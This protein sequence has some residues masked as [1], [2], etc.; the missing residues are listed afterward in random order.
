VSTISPAG[1]RFPGPDSGLQVNFCKNVS[2]A[3]FG[4]PETLH[5]KRRLPEATPQPGDYSRH[6]ANAN[7][8]MKC[9]VCGS[10]NPVRSNLGIVEER[11]RLCAPMTGKPAPS[12]P[13][14]ACSNYGISVS[15]P[16]SY[17]RF[18]KTKVGTPRWRCNACKKTFSENGAPLNRQRKA[19]K[20]R[21]VFALL[22]NKSPL[23]RI[24]EVTGLDPKTL[25]GKF[26][27]IHRQ[28]L[29]FAGQR[30]MP[31]LHG[32]RLPKLYLAVDRQS[33]TV[34]W[35]SRNDRRNVTLSAIASADLESGYVFGFHLN[36]DPRLDP[37]QVEAEAAVLRDTAHM[38]AFRRFARVWLAHDYDA[39]V[40]TAALLSPVKRAS[41]P[42][43]DKLR[44]TIERT[45]AAAQARPDVEAPDHKSEDETLPAMG[46]QV[47]EQ[48]TMHG[49]FQMLAAM[50]QGAEKVRVYMDQDS[51]IRAAFLAAFADRIKERTA[52]GWYVSVLKES[53]IHEKEHAVQKARLR[54]EDC[55][56]RNPGLSDHGLHLALMMGEMAQATALG[57]YGDKWLAHPVPSMSEPAK[58]VCWLTDMGDYE[59]EHAARLYLRASLHA[60][61]RFFMQARRRLSLAERA[62]ITASKD[63]RVWHGYAAYKPENLAMVLEIFRV[64]YNYCKAGKDKKTPAMRLGLAKAPI[65]LEDVLYFRPIN[66]RA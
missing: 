26:A 36:F 21:D 38:E 51:G 32:M 46:M 43:P 28:C 31:L 66:H 44:D 45:Y 7:T 40:E 8:V 34:N 4:V 1:H 30:E 16:G 39:A 14:E 23:K 55:K 61:D 29:A 65:P 27:F 33:H 41:S 11:A 2:C 52:D 56:E 3:A 42:K 47:R 25:Y 57:N 35:S 6:G 60:V 18:G 62:I 19:H 53:T 17:A 59:Q 37:T 54:L 63:R 20:N 12:C 10:F 5:R 9:G 49:H 64:F 50:L 22:M 58:K 48:Y 15:T 13:V 24:A